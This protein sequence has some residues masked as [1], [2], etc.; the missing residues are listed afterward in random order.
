MRELGFKR[1]YRHFEDGLKAT[2]EWY[3]QNDV[4]REQVLAAAKTR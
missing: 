4:W 2:I 3:L 1:E